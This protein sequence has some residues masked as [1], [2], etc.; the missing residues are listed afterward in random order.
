MLISGLPIKLTRS[1][2]DVFHSYDEKYYLVW[3]DGV[4]VG[5]HEGLG[6]LAD[7]TGDHA[8]VDGLDV[9]DLADDH[10]PV[11]FLFSLGVNGIAEE[12]HGGQVGKL[13]ALCDLIL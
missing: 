3:R 9:G 13:G 4:E 6:S 2:I 11:V 12:E 8:S 5:S 1:I 10:G 7:F